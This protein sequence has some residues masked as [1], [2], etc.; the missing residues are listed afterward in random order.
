MKSEEFIKVL[1]ERIEID[2][3]ELSDAVDNLPPKEKAM[4]C[5]ANDKMID[6]ICDN[7]PIKYHELQVK[8]LTLVILW[9]LKKKKGKQK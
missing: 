5:T 6:Y 4:I 8:S 2:I 7:I 9:G 3:K 1:G